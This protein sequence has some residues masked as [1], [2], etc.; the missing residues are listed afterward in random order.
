[1]K[2]RLAILGRLGVG[3]ARDLERDFDVIEESLRVVKWH[4]L[5]TEPGMALEAAR[6][7]IR[8]AT[9][10]TQCLLGH[11]APV[12]SEP[13]SVHLAALLRGLLDGFGGVLAS[14]VRLVVEIEDGLPPVSG[15]IDD[16]E[17]LVL[18]VLLH[19]ADRVAE[20]GYVLLSLHREDTSTLVV[21]VAHSG[22]PETVEE[23]AGSGP[24][25][26]VALTI[27]ERHGAR[28]HCLPRPGGGERSLIAFP[29]DDDR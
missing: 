18:D 19:A 23:A 10:L 27:A 28:L 5:G 1:M 29:L 24:L 26:G 14:G 6:D 17:L 15:A 2:D 7:A 22:R 20:N 3:V 4:G 13:T 8:H 21:E 11:A 16:F 25:L 9:R 12:K